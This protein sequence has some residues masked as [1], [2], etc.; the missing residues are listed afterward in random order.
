[1]GG[2][3]ASSTEN[4][5]EMALSAVAGRLDMAEIGAGGTVWNR[6]LRRDYAVGLGWHAN[7]VTAS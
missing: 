6:S 4:S 1:M 3:T 5:E 7:T 2:G